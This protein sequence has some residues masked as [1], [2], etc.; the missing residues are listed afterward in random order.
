MR[1]SL[2]IAGRVRGITLVMVLVFL[3]IFA[4]IAV[5]IAKRTNLELRMTGNAQSK[6]QTFEQ[7]E[8][9]RIAAEADAAR[10]TDALN[11]GAAFDC[12]VGGHYAA[13][14]ATGTTGT[15]APL[16]ADQLTWSDSDSIAAGDGRYAIEY[17][18]KSAVVLQ[19]DRLMLPRRFTTVHI[20]RILARGSEAS[21]GR[22]VLETVYLRRS[23]N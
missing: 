18:G 13:A 2:P 5:F 3:V 12:N 17:E 20:F 4:G 23:A 15:C 7:A 11:T 9:A 21:G 16:S 14:G 22:T 10:I 6:T 1:K 19:E 8:A